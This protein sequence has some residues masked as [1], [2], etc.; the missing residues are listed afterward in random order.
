MKH[1]ETV[2]AYWNKRTEEIHFLRHCRSSVAPEKM[3]GDYEVEIS[4]FEK[5]KTFEEPEQDSH[6]TVNRATRFCPNN[7]RIARVRLASSTKRY[8]AVI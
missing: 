1:A 8:F 6:S 2:D 7:R 4:G 3:V 5:C